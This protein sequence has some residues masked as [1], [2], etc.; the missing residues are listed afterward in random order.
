MIGI[1]WTTTPR[2]PWCWAPAKSPWACSCSSTTR[3]APIGSAA[4]GPSPT[5]GGSRSP[6]PCAPTSCIRA[7]AHAGATE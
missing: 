6:R 4:T 7:R 2:P 1:S 3:C 5:M